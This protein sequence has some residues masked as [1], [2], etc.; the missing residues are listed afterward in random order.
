MLD[1]L[2]YCIVVAEAACLR[3]NAES[4]V[5][6]SDCLADDDSGLQVA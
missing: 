2:H 3:N 4:L 5:S 6:R 1:G